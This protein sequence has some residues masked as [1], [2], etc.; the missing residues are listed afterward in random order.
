MKINRRSARKRTRMGIAGLHGSRGSRRL[1]GNHGRAIN[2]APTS[3]PGNHPR[4]K[5]TILFPME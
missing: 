1:S 4:E 3:R 2:R 5:K